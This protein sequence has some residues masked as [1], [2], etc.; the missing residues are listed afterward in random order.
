MVGEQLQEL[1][2]AVD[3]VQDD[4]FQSLDVLLVSYELHKFQL[5]ILDVVFLEDL[6]EAELGHLDHGL[7]LSLGLESDLL[8]FESDDFV[9]GFDRL[10]GDFQEEVDLQQPNF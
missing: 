2:V 7:Q 5:L 4:C 6:G 10:L 1:D 9:V 3:G 8:P